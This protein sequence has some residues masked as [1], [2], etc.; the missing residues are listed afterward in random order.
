MRHDSD[1]QDA[2]YQELAT[3]FWMTDACCYPD[4]AEKLELVLF[5]DLVFFDQVLQDFVV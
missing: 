1:S 5:W 4:A 2:D 3:T